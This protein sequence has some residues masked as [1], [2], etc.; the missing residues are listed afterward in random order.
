MSYLTSA[1]SR[2][3]FLAKKFNKTKS[4][5]T[6][7]T[8]DQA[9]K[10]FDRFTKEKFNKDATEEIIEDIKIIDDKKRN[11]IVLDVLQQYVDWRQTQALA[12]TV[13]LHFNFIKNYF[14]Y[15]GIKLYPQDIRDGITLPQKNKDLMHAVTK[16]EMRKILDNSS[17]KR[18]ALY[19]TL[20][21]SGMRIQEACALR[22]RDF[23][24]TGKR[25][26]ITIP[27]KFTKRKIQRETYISKEAEE[28]IRPI[29]GRLAPDDLVFSTNENIHHG[30][31][32]EERVFHQCRIRA[33]LTKRLDSSPDHLITLKSFRAFC[34]TAASNIH[35]LEYAHALIGHSGYLDQYYR[36]SPEERLEKYVQIEPY[37]TIY[38]DVDFVKTA[39]EMRKKIAEIEQKKN[40]DFELLKGQFKK[41]H[42]KVVELDKANELLQYWI[43]KLRGKTTKAD[44]EKFNEE[45]S[46]YRKLYITEAILDPSLRELIT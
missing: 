39:E 14:F 28:Y 40:D 8:Y 32:N 12:S 33:G 37:L 27:A 6:R 15:H 11:D 25:V 17:E 29:L 10:S 31:Q 34:E 19:L 45:F 3:A 24:L 16:E 41:D 36:L 7:I 44:D 46:K 13:K 35:G 23:D 30:K 21:S 20:L 4:E 42:E 18:K 1:K 9:L 5:N 43:N 22:K 38:G 26:K 2:E